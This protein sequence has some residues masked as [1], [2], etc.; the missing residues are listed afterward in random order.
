MQLTKE[1][2]VRFSDNFGKRPNILQYPNEVLGLAKKKATSFH[3]SEEIWNNPLDI[4]TGMSRTQLDELRTGWDLVLDI[5]CKFIEYS[6]IAADKIIE[7]LKYKNAENVSLKFSGNNGFHIGLPYESFPEKI[8]GKET[9]L[10]FP[11]AAK[12][13]A[14]YVRQMIKDHVAE[15]ILGTEA[16]K[17]N[18]VAEKTG[19]LPQKLY[20]KKKR[21]TGSGTA[22]EHRHYSAVLPSS[23][24]N[25]LFSS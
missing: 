16:G 18:N 3:A 6:K 17:Y 4:E 7:L 12:R 1:I 19:I 5:D 13:V 20:D 9:R 22:I 8:H 14:L 21:Q 24:Q 15:E 23:L 11:E 10:L 25:A 2:A